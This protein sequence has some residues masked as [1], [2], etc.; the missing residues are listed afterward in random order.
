MTLK[1]VA[2]EGLTLDHGAGSPISGGNFTVT[3][4]ASPK[5]SAESKG[6]FFAQISFTFSGG[7]ASGFDPGTVAGGGTIAATATKVK[8]STGYVM[9]VGDSVT[10][11]ASG[12]VGGTPTPVSGPVEISDAGQSKVSAQ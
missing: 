10:M 11:T 3:A 8:D 6:V 2:V 7:N 1:Y 5:V 12:T 9:R 4:I